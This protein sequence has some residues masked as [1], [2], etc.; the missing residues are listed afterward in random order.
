M[1]RM[2][3]EAKASRKV[4]G[5]VSIVS[6]VVRQ[7]CCLSA[8]C[9]GSTISCKSHYFG[10]NNLIM[11]Q[12]SNHLT[13]VLKDK[14]LRVLLYIAAILL[15]VFFTVIV[16]KAIGGKHVKV[17][18]MEIN[19]PEEGPFTSGHKK[20]VDSDTTRSQDVS[21]KIIPS[22]GKSEEP[23]AN[24]SHRKEA[25]S[26]KVK[27]EVVRPNKTLSSDS[28]KISVG[29]IQGENVNVG[30]NY[31]QVGN[32][33]FTEKELSA[34]NVSALIS[35]IEQLISQNNFEKNHVVLFRAA[36]MN[37]GKIYRQVSDALKDKGYI[38]SPGTSP[39]TVKQ[40]SFTNVDGALG[41]T[42]GE[43]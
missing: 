42:I 40:F 41:V 7:P 5:L 2:G 20:P 38:I 4:H 6:G 43:F 9:V 18:G 27:S 31:G 13:E 39:A 11:T 28:P 36:N 19:M 23:T 33:Y 34:P 8:W 22:H 14:F 35:H 15:I 30:P 24:K 10:G 29:S 16:V 25:S 21:E 17:F 26:E 32:N 12:N 3:I 37:S 1:P